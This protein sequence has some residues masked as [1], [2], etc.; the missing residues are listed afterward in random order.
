[1]ARS[2][3]GLPVV[4]DTQAVAAPR[5]SGLRRMRR[6][7]GALP[8]YRAFVAMEATMLALAAAIVD[9]IAGDLIGSR[10]LVIALVAMTAITAL[11][12]LVAIITSDRLR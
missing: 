2:E 4:A 3:A 10:V 5:P 8:F 7:M 9:A 6:A 11:G 1:V 12:H